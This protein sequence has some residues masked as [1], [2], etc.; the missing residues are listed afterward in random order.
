MPLAPGT[1]LG[2]YEVIAPLGAGGT[3]EVF[4]ARDTLLN[5]E[6]ALEVLPEPQ[7]LAEAR[8]A[9]GLKH[10]SI[11]AVYDV[12]EEAGIAYMVSELV[13][14]RTLRALLAGGPLPQHQAVDLAAQIADAAAAA[15]AA[16]ITHLGLQPGN[17][18]VAVGGRVKVLD[19]GLAGQGPAARQGTIWYT[20]PELAR[21]WP[22]DA[23]SDLFSIGAVLYEMLS[24]SRP[25]ERASDAATLSAILKE[26]PPEL[27]PAVAPVL[28]EM[29]SRCLVK[30]AAHRFQSAAD[31]AFALRSIAGVATSITAAA[32]APLHPRRN[33]WLAPLAA[34]GGGAILFIGGFLVHARMT[35]HE[36]PRF[37]RITFRKGQV[38]SARFL[39][40]GKNVVYVANPEG[41]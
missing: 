25:F 2:P 40:D 35:R 34:A 26:E 22:A 12:G 19:F 15:H 32:V 13:E 16:G 31:L 24:G 20:S 30:D 1:R 14:G 37:Q 27:P 23:R 3:G 9:A 11:A 28:R 33:R 6:V 5:R 39:P 17:I 7:T 41:G 10:P 36:S 4:R 38:A 21:G 8:A 29:V 18:V